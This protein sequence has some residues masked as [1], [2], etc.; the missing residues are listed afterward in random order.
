MKV[1]FPSHLFFVSRPPPRSKRRPRSPRSFHAASTLCSTCPVSSTAS[2]WN[3]ARHHI[4]Y[5]ASSPRTHRTAPRR[6]APRIGSSSCWWSSSQ[7]QCA[8]RKITVCSHPP[9][10]ATQACAPTTSRSGLTLRLCIVLRPLPPQPTACLR[11]SIGGSEMQRHHWF[12]MQFFCVP[13]V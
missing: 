12:E 8:A 9:T 10:H 3:R 11:V 4:V 1:G 7:W 2:R 13:G 5:T 6:A